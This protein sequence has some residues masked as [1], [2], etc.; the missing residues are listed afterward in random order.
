MAQE[1]A[2]SRAKLWRDWK[3]NEQF[4]VFPE[5]PSRTCSAPMPRSSGLRRSLESFLGGQ[6]SWPP[7][8]MPRSSGCR[9]AKSRM[10]GKR[11]F[12]TRRNGMI[13]NK[14][15]SVFFSNCQTE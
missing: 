7:R 5:L 15:S 13:E 4:G 14:S 1:T 2:P 6:N 8:P 3:C 9:F 10:M 12:C 11:S